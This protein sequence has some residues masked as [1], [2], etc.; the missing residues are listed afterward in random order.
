MKRK[1]AMKRMLLSV[2]A[3]V[4]MPALFAQ[5]LPVDTLQTSVTLGE[6]EV[7][8]STVVDK[9]DRKLFIPTSE[10]ARQSANAVDLLQRMQMPELRVDMVNDA[11]TLVD[12]GVLDI[13]IN[14]RKA[15]VYD[16]KGIDPGSVTR[17]EYHRNPSMR[18]GEV[19][20][21][22][23]F[24]VV[25]HKSG[26]SF[27]V[28]GKQAASGWGG[29]YANLKLNNKK[30][31]FG[32][33]G[34]YNPRRDFEMWRD[35]VENYKL[36]DGTAFTRTETGLP[37]R[38]DAPNYG[39][40]LDYSY[41]KDDKMLLFV[42]LSASGGWNDRNEYNGIYANSL[43]AEKSKVSDLL[44]IQ[45]FRPNLNVYWQYDI[46]KSK[47]IVVDLTASD[48][49]SDS[50]RSY[51]TYEYIEDGSD[52]EELSSIFTKIKSN[53]YSLIANANYEQRFDAGRLTAGVRY[54]H[55]WGRNDYMTS[56]VIDKTRESDTRVYAEWWQP[57]GSSFDYQ[58]GLSAV[59]RRFRI[60]GYDAVS[61]LDFIYS[62]RMRY[63]I[64]SYSTLRFNFTTETVSPTANELSQAVQD[65]DEYQKYRGNPS[66]KPYRRYIGE[67]HYEYARGIFLGNLATALRYTDNPVM[68]EKYWETGSDGGWYLLNTVRNQKYH[69][70]FKVFAN[71]RVEAIP[72]WLTVGASFG[73]KHSVSRGWEYRHV[74]NK[75][76]Y[77]DWSVVLSHWNFSLMYNGHTN[78]RDLWGET[79][80]GTENYQ[81]IILSYKHKDLYVGVGIINPFMKNYNIPTENLNEFAGYDRKMHLTMA[82]NLA[83]VMLRYNIQ[84]GRKQRDIEKRVNNVYEGGAVNATGK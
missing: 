26:G 12:K 53:S 33:S 45:S 46:D 68:E 27:Y 29:Y 57:L 35:N 1:D 50:E 6:V 40:F 80:T 22:V 67:L 32:V 49:Y 74:M 9:S 70:T 71:A 42:Q 23:D 15:T 13:R 82:Q 21:V 61:T 76:V 3:V 64:G 55:G 65:I 7:K 18:Y 72:G 4:S 56:R 47:Q 58:A 38:M 24:I 41:R 73:W 51:A 5:A 16:L 28:E 78:S 83:F 69:S 34:W 62:L 30:S 2:I 31:Q 43:S 36:P 17:V 10:Q 44:H 77:A 19:D 20:A 11:I 79:I 75:S 48:Y 39:F 14:G 66:L 54:L 25:Q 60:I 37:G 8:G 63:K 52:G 84:W 81:D 59:G